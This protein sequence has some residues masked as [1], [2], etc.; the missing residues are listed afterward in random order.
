MDILEKCRTPLHWTILYKE[1]DDALI[2][3]KDRSV[4]I[5]ALDHRHNTAMVYLLRKFR[6]LRRL[7]TK[8]NEKQMMLYEAMIVHPEID[9]K[10]TSDSGKSIREYIIDCK[11]PELYD[12]IFQHTKWIY[13]DLMTSI[14]FDNKYVFLM[15][16]EYYK[17]KKISINEWNEDN[18]TALECS[19]WNEDLFYCEALCQAG[20]LDEGGKC[21]Y[22][23]E[24]REQVE[25]RRIME[26]YNCSRKLLEDIPQEM[27]WY[28]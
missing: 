10:Q 27:E 2:I 6:E 20:A 26:K 13:E 11:I 14:T 19:L 1:Y 17:S 22:F 7:E 18:M 15:L 8:P 3:L 5:N 28:E 4:D 25:H 16:L 24:L 9:L 12:I 23:A 21:M